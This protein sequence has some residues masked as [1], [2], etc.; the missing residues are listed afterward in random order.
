[1]ILKYSSFK[2]FKLFDEQNSYFDGNKI[3][4]FFNKNCKPCSLS[5]FLHQSHVHSDLNSKNCFFF[6]KSNS[7]STYT[8]A[9]KESVA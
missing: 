2:S 1:M 4:F 3:I 6:L 5:I 7:R 8:K 9:T